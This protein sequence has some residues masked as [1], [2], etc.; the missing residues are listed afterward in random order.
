[1]K[2][3]VFLHPCALSLRET[4][5]ITRAIAFLLTILGV[6]NLPTAAS[7][8]PLRDVQLSVQS[9]G[10]LNTFTYS[11]Y[12]NQRGQRVAGQSA[13]AQNNAS[14]KRDGVILWSEIRGAAPSSTSFNFRVYDPIRG[15]W[16][17]LNTAFSNGNSVARTVGAVAEWSEIQY[18]SNNTQT[19]NHRFGI[20]DPELG[21]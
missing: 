5:R 7:M 4:S 21:Q 15:S 10:N 3:N 18:Q 14:T 6:A 2:L 20:Y 1:M 11:V 12:D 13:L 8:P 19:T 16:A 9:S 17:A